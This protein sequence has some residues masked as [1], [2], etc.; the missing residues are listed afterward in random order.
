LPKEE[1]SR[2]PLHPVVDS[3]DQSSA[4]EQDHGDEVAP[5]GSTAGDVSPEMESFPGPSVTR[6][7]G[8]P[9][10]AP[11]AGTTDSAFDPLRVRLPVYDGP[12]DLLLDLIKKNE[13]NIY[14]IPIAEITKQ[15]LDYLHR[16]KQLDLEV[17]GEFVVMAA[18]L[19]YIKSRTL[20]PTDKE[21]EENEGE[22]PRAELVKKLLEYQA[23]K[24]AARELGLLQTERGKMF[25]RQISDYYLSEM[26]PEDAGIDTFSANFFD[27]VVAFQNVLAKK[28]RE[29]PHEVF[30]EVISIEEKM[31]EIQAVLIEKNKM[32]FTELFSGRWSRN[33]LV[34]TFLAI[35]EIVRTRFAR[36][37]Q[38]KTF[39]EIVIE[40][41]DE[42][43]YKST[44]QNKPAAE[45][46]EPPVA[47]TDE[48]QPTD[49]G[50]HTI[51][52]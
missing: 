25:T 31:V 14:D 33:E 32:R 50:N 4:N 44:S 5:D 36:V 51:G 13:M 19:I 45:N 6:E 38:D 27:L 49:T 7:E 2:D 11:V 39:G 1:E 10:P 37:F 34:A 48:P 9:E 8:T 35:L 22:D 52:S 40:K 18:T 28:E 41:R 29:K 15:Y 46:A 26:K 3:G 12:L 47:G 17:A 43:G 24:E 42:S 23:F 21:V 16:M 30:E 20:L